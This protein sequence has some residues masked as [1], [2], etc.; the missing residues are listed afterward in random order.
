[1]TYKLLNLVRRRTRYIQ[2]VLLLRSGFCSVLQ[3]VA[4]LDSCVRGLDS[5]GQ[6]V[7]KSRAGGGFRKDQ[8]V[9]KDPNEKTCERRHLD[10]IE[11]R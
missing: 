11:E 10:Q 1:M 2:V 7:S 6:A 3:K 8:V 9:S 4:I 5:R